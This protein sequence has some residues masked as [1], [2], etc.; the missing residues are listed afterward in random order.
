MS[1]SS[2]KDQWSGVRE[3][4]TAIVLS[5][6]V[7]GLSYYCFFLM[8]P[9]IWS[10]NIPFKPEDLVPLVLEATAEHDGIEIYA[11]YI[12][13]F[14]SSITALLLSRF[15][16]CIPLKSSRIIITLCAFASCFYCL[17][18][19]FTPPMSNVATLPLTAIAQKSL[20]IILISLTFLAL[21]F[22]LQKRSPRAVFIISAIM[23]IP[24]CFIA[25]SSISMFDYSF[26]FSPALR[27][28]N[29]AAIRDIYFQYELLPSLLAVAWMKLGF[30]LNGYQVLGQ[31]A[32]FIAILGVFIFSGRLLHR[33]ELS[34]V[35]LVTLVIVRIYA[36][37][38]DVI[39]CFQ[40]TPIRLDFWLPL[41]AVVYWR[42][43]YHWT[44]GVV[45]GLLI[46]LL[47]NLGIIY[48]LAYFQLLITLF[49]L[50]FLD[51][52]TRASFFRDLAE[53]GR[54]CSK[55]LALICCAGAACFLLFHNPEYPNY[56]GYYQKLGIGFIQISR[57]SFYW[58]ILA[59]ISTVIILLFKLR[60]SVPPAYLICG[61]L[62]T[63][64][65][66]G[67]SIYFFGRS[68]E[69]NILN[70]SIVLLFLC[71]FLLDLVS[72]L[73]HEDSADNGSFS[74]LR[75]NVSICAALVIVLASIISYSDVISEKGSLQLAQISKGRTIFP[76]G[77][78]RQAYTDVFNRIRLL[79]NNSSR[80]YFVGGPDFDFYYYGG[81]APVGYCNPFPTWIFNKDL[82]RFL[83]GLLDNGYYLVCNN[84]MKYLLTNLQYNDVNSIGS[85][86][87][88][89][90]LPRRGP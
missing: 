39:Y 52:G 78:S 77:Y 48:T 66:I 35:L 44:A 22:Y 41:L 1:G 37:P 85:S 90:K 23:L 2:S 74:V 46:L 31:L 65:A 70:I 32:Y 42:G 26:I 25:T 57:T 61:F 40:V 15:I 59:M 14:V 67:N 84:T 73:L 16:D 18:I 28:I 27:L 71:F 33:K 81:Y 83:Q 60:N 6:A 34:L 10:K 20:P 79:T 55:P 19:G 51:N 36:S 38:W 76:L 69:H 80:V 8:T 58:Y 82:T 4:F 7:A 29:G 54:R 88:V 47:K 62:L 56:S 50:R 68:H 86:V 43:P 45:C 75:R 89:S 13:V 87:V 49:A 72:R 17:T 21:M 30:D 12:M 3:L 53:H 5:L 9:W 64:C 63:Y 24:I 11:L